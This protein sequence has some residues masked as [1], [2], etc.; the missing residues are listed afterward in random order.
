MSC[1]ILRF[2]NSGAAERSGGGLESL[3][4]YSGSVVDLII[5]TSALASLFYSI[6]V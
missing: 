1:L 2:S 5:G 6:R 4:L 3:L